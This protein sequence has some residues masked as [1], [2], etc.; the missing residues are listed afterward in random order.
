VGELEEHIQKLKDEF[1]RIKGDGEG[2]ITLTETDEELI[3]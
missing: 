1:S 3:R 2:G